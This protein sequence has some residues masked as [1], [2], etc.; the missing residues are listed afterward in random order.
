[1]MVARRQMRGSRRLLGDSEET[2]SLEGASSATWA[3]RLF[4]PRPR[5]WDVIAFVLF[6]TKINNI[7]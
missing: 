1:M 7:F 6:C 5:V 3:W 2:W 4:C